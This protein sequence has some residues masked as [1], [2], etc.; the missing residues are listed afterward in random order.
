MI[1]VVIGLCFITLSLMLVMMI[2]V[3]INATLEN[4]LLWYKDW[5]EFEKQY[6]RKVYELQTDLE[7]AN[8]ELE[9]LRVK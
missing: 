2:L 8:R 3:K 1:S 5:I 6:K 7:T 4:A 9:K